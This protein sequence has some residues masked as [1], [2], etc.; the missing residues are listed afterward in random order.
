VVLGLLHVERRLTTLGEPP[1][2]EGQLLE[3]RHM[4]LSHHGKL[5]FGSPVVPMTLEAQ[6]VHQADDASAKATD[7][8]DAFDDGELWA[9]GGAFSKRAGSS[10]G[11]SGGER[12]T[13]TR[14]GAPPTVLACQ[15]RAIDTRRAP[16][17]ARN[18]LATRSEPRLNPAERPCITTDDVIIIRGRISAHPYGRG[19]TNLE[20]SCESHVRTRTTRRRR[21]T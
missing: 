12:T 8:L 9:D 15:R 6:I 21:S 17:C 1:C 13:G 10:A 14:T 3:L 4:I 7:F 5:E 18:T 11:R 2:T 20:G 19:G 16:E